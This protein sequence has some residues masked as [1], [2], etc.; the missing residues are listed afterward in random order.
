MFGGTARLRY[1]GRR[2]AG[3]EEPSP[4]PA[5]A[6]TFLLET[7]VT[8][9]TT[10]EC[11]PCKGGVPT[12]T[13]NEILKLA[14]QVPEW[15]VTEVDGIRRL[16]REFRFA[17]FV[18]AMSF[19]VKVGDLAEKEQHHPDLHVAWGK[20]GVEIWTHKIKGLHENDFILAAKIDK[21]AD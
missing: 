13:D 6:S 7:T 14:P 2:A 12:L 16:Q 4:A 21:L 5:G 15:R 3:C 1:D 17:D 9:L 8:D 10:K 20:V 11:V 19:A 18:S